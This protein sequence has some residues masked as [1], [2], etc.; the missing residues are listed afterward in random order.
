M[1]ELSIISLEQ[2][3]KE[4]MFIY[5]ERGFLDLLANHKKMGLKINQF[6]G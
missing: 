5:V 2:A 1:R 6:V 4:K 3:D